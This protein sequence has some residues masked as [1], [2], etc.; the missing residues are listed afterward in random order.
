MRLRLWVRS[1]NSIRDRPCFLLLPWR[2]Q[3][4][5]GGGSARQGRNGGVPQ[6]A[7]K[8]L[9]RGLTRF[10]APIRDRP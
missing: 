4:N 8:A 5:R 10:P 6:K 9:C 1:K 3:P 2:R 7:R